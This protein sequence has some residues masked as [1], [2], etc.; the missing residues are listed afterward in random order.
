M[1]EMVFPA[2]KVKM[3]PLI[4]CMPGMRKG[5]DRDKQTD[6]QKNEKTAQQD[7]SSQRYSGPTHLLHGFSLRDFASA[8]EQKPI[9]AE[10]SMV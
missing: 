9:S 3:A 5:A 4:I 7:S 2:I 10:A 1:M 8:R 6:G